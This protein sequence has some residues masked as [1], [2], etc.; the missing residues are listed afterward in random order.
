LLGEVASA[1]LDRIVNETAY[2]QVPSSKDWQPYQYLQIV[3]G[4]LCVLAH[5]LALHQHVCW[6]V[7]TMLRTC[8]IETTRPVL[9]VRVNTVQTAAVP[10]GAVSGQEARPIAPTYAQADEILRVLEATSVMV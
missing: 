8:I 5:L 2:C 10:K 6:D 4:S 3:Y 1:S 9:A 7:S